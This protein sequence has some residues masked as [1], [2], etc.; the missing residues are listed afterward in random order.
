[1]SKSQLLYC[2]GHLTT[3]AVLASSAEVMQST[4]QYLHD[5]YGSAAQ[6][7]K[8]IGLTST[9]VSLIR[10]NLMKEAATTDLVARMAKSAHLEGGHQHGACAPLYS[11]RVVMLQLVLRI[12]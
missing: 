2:A 10:L 7:A 6:Y 1:M 9:E 5:K 8:I 11:P 4:I 3:D 12:A